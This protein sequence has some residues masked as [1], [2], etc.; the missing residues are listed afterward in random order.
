MIILGFY[1]PHILWEQAFFIEQHLLQP[2]HIIKRFYMNSIVILF[3]GNVG[4]NII[5]EE[6]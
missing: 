5:C 3:Q 1:F 6:Q 4:T 2:L